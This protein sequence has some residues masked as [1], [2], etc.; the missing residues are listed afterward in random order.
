MNALWSPGVAHAKQEF[1]GSQC[2]R[3]S[4][5]KMTSGRW[6]VSLRGCSCSMDNLD[7]KKE[8]YFFSHLSGTPQPIHVPTPL[9]KSGHPPLQQEIQSST[10]ASE[11]DWARCTPM[12]S[13]TRASTGQRCFSG[14]G[15]TAGVLK[16]LPIRQ[17]QLI[18]GRQVLEV[19]RGWHSCRSRRQFIQRRQALSQPG[20]RPVRLRA[21]NSLLCER[22]CSNQA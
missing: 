1:P 11:P 3:N 12:S 4:S 9:L 6:R 17:Q 22:G 21:F 14:T 8:E 16:L 19:C 5:R 20:F 2:Q 7:F 15:E 13:G 18:L 10:P